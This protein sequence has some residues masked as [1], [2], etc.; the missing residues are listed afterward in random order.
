MNKHIPIAA[1][2]LCP[3]LLVLSLGW[4][5]PRAQRAAASRLP[6]AQASSPTIDFQTIQLPI[7]SSEQDRAYLGLSGTGHFRVGQLKSRVLLIEVFSFYCIHCQRTAPRMNEVFQEIQKR[8]AWRE[9]VKMIGIGVG[10]SPL[11]VKS[12]KEKF[13]VPFP[14]FPDQ[15]MNTC[16]AMGIEAT[17]TFIG[18]RRNETG[19]GERFYFEEGEFP[20]ALKF[21]EK[22]IRLA[23]LEQEGQK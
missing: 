13:Q 15:S 6:G 18:V 23:G 7:P 16:K 19:L 12:Y 2:L 8:P 20:D 10:N 1:A 22:V 3:L 11:E 21:L 9:N 5:G 17:P 4:A 14:L